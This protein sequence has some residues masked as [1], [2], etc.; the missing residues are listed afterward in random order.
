MS[1]LFH[2]HTIHL[3]DQH[4]LHFTHRHGEFRIV[5]QFLKEKST[6]S[7]IARLVLDFNLLRSL[8]TESIIEIENPIVPLQFS[9]SVEQ[10]IFDFKQR[11]ITLRAVEVVKVFTI[12]EDE[13]IG[14]LSYMKKGSDL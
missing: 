11:T 3:Q 12:S 6:F 2:T 8:E 9:V 1:K 14:L 7:W 5:V 13:W 10:T 4:A